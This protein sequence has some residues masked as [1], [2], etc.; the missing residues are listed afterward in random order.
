MKLKQRFS[1]LEVRSRRWSIFVV[2]ALAGMSL[3]VV[4]HDQ[5][6]AETYS[7]LAA[8]AGACAAVLLS[9]AALQY[10]RARAL[11][12]PRAIRRALYSAERATQAVMLFIVAVCLGGTV[13]GLSA[14]LPE[15]F[16]VNANEYF[17]A[18]RFVLIGLTLLIVI[19]AYG[20]FYLALRSAVVGV[21]RT[22]SARQMVRHL[23]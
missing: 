14:A 13:A 9:F 4:I 12:R 7:T 2:Y 20:C 5:L 3:F 22:V 16:A 21:F 8:V 1:R 11:S 15:L 18:L 23:L 6:M 10:N 19:S 17:A